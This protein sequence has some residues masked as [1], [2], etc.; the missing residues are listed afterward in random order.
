MRAGAQPGR[1]VSTPGRFRTPGPPAP[2]AVAQPRST[3]RAR[4]PLSSHPAADRADAGRSL[5]A[6]EGRIATRLYLQ[7]LKCKGS[8]ERRCTLLPT[9]PLRGQVSHCSLGSL[10][11]SP[12]R[13]RLQGSTRQAGRKKPTLL[14]FPAFL[15]PSAKG[16]LTRL[17]LCPKPG[18]GA[19]RASLTAA[20]V[21]LKLLHSPPSR[22]TGDN[23]RQLQGQ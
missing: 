13:R 22:K 11:P 6:G 7:S 15:S 12:S 2:S 20:R 19:G 3:S 10:P 4:A 21:S 9:E 16:G 1:P 8:R 23:L 17:P 14:A 18:A 5:S